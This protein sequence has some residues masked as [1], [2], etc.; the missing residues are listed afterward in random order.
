MEDLSH[1]DFAE[2][3]SG[4]DAAA[5][6]LGFEP[7]R[8]APSD[9]KVWVVEQRLAQDYARAL[10]YALSE[11]NAFVDDR[12]LQDL[13]AKRPEDLL[14]SVKL[15]QMW[16]DVTAGIE[17]AD[18]DLMRDEELPDFQNQLFSRSAIVRWLNALVIS[19]KYQFDRRHNGNRSEI[20]KDEIDPEELPF[21]LDVGLI[22]FRAVRNGFGDPNATYRNRLEA[23][24]RKH[25]NK[26]KESE[27]DRIA[28]VANPDKERGRKKY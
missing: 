25:Y 5:L 27:I 17:G 8:A 21:E 10:Q 15:N 3:F 7:R 11:I 24:L 2:H 9:H 12:L 23:Y 6:I 22:A 28:T 26:L 13:I 20:Q 14:L 4:H 18:F 16:C 1:W 19:S